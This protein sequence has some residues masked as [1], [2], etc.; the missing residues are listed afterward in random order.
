M[1]VFIY[2]AEYSIIMGTVMELSVMELKGINTLI[3]EH[4]LS[5]TE[6]LLTN[7]KRWITINE[8]IQHVIEGNKGG[9]R[10]EIRG[11]IK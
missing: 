7:L 4:I 6:H 8:G 1:K 5:G 3:E 11:V 10:L 9:D 2:Y